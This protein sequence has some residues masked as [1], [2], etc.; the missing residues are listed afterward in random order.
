MFGPQGAAINAGAADDI[1]VV[2]VGN[3]ANTNTLIAAASAPDIPADRFT[4]LT[5]LDHNRPSAGSPTPS[6]RVPT[7]SPS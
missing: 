1:R 4:A 5:R 2:V 7:K 3:T 6:M